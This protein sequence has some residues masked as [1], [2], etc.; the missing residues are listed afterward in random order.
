M[1][2]VRVCNPAAPSRKFKSQ[3]RLPLENS[4]IYIIE[5]LYL[6]IC[7]ARVVHS[8]SISL[9]F[10]PS[11]HVVT[12]P[13]ELKQKCWVT[14]VWESFIFVYFREYFGHDV[15]SA[16]KDM[17]DVWFSFARRRAIWQCV[18]KKKSLPGRKG[19]LDWIHYQY[20]TEKEVEKGCRVIVVCHFYFFISLPIFSF[21]YMYV[22]SEMYIG[23]CMG[24]TT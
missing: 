22:V 8:E 18:T 19:R 14:R 6:C 10:H 5:K 2:N 16:L 12:E 21:F 9:F 15:H 3:S 23:C 24:T 17:G 4:R 13:S 7:L 1:I 11:V 20:S